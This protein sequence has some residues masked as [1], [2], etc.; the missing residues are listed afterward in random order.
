[1]CGSSEV[2]CLIDPGCWDEQDIAQAQKVR[3]D[4]DYFMPG[5]MVETNIQADDYPDC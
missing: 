2:F 3:E 4:L 5:K 1:M